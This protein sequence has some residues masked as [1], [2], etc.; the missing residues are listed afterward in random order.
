MVGVESVDVPALAAVCEHYGVVELSV[1]G[2]VATGRQSASSDVD[3]LYVLRNGAHLGWAVNDLSDDLERVLGTT[4]DL[5]SK[6]TLNAR[7]RD[8]VLAQ[9]QVL[10]EA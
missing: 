2:S 6:K 1:F 4:V 8:E 7:L 9:A 5:V 3:L 10:Y